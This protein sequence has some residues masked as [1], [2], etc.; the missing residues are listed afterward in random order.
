LITSI[1]FEEL[2]ILPTPEQDNSLHLAGNVRQIE[3]EW[4]EE[5]NVEGM[6]E[7]DKAIL[8][9]KRQNRVVIKSYSDDFALNYDDH[10]GNGAKPLI[11]LPIN[12]KALFLIPYIICAALL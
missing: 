7:K 10:S 6:T 5:E 8:R 1:Q 3:D 2:K 4:V 12:I 9:E 11:L